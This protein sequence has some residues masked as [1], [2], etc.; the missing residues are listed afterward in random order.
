MR[1]LA[2]RDTLPELLAPCDVFL[3]ASTTESFGLSAL[4][5]MAC[6]VPVV[7]TRVGGLREVVEH[8]KTGLLAAP[9]DREA[10]AAAIH[11]LLFDRERSAALGA[12]ARSQVE[13]CF[14]RERVVAHYE[15][16]YRRA[17]AR[18]GVEA[19]STGS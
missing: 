4:E 5:A 1:F 2:E 17:L 12:A 9:D 14:T 18:P 3:L 11:E 13:R 10:F 19:R 6:G 7:A 15:S 16:L 8:E